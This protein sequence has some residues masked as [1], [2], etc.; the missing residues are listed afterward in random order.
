[1]GCPELLKV[2]AKRRPQLV[3]GGHI[4]GAHGVEEG[5]GEL[6]GVTFVNARSGFLIQICN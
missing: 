2:A 5:K 4:H 1:V 6:C 3:V